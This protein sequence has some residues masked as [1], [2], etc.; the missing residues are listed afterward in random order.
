VC[1]KTFNGTYISMG[2]GLAAGQSYIN[3]AL[4]FRLQLFDLAPGPTG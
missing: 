2:E 1:I 4:K 3:R